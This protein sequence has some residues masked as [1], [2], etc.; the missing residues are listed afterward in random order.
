M[1]IYDKNG[2]VYLQCETQLESDVL[3]E[4]SKKLE[5][6]LDELIAEGIKKS[7]TLVSR[8]KH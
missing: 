2:T 4:N 7:A 6:K 8:P 1:K 5:D 3:K